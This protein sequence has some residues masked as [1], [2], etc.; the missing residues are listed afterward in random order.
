IFLLKIPSKIK[1]GENGQKAI[2]MLDDMRRPFLEIKEA[3][4]R[5]IETGNIKSAYSDFSKAV[6]SAD[7][8]LFRYKQ[9]AQ[10]NPDLFRNVVQLSKVY[11]EW[12]ITERYLFDYYHAIS[13]YDL[14]IASERLLNTMSRLG[15]GEIPIH[16]DISA[17][18]KAN[19]AL[20]TLAG[21]L[22]LYLIGL[23][24][25]Q[26]RARARTF[27]ILL[28]DR[29]SALKLVE[30]K[31]GELETALLKSESA[32]RAKSDFLSNM[33]HELRTPLNSVI[34]F[35]EVLTE[36]LA[37]SITD[38]QKEYVLNIWKSGRHLLRL[39]ND[40]MDLSKIEAGKM[41]LE[42]SDFDLKQLIEG[43]LLLFKEKSIKHSIGLRSDIPYDTCLITADERK[44]KQVILNLL[45]NA[46]KFMDD[47]GSVSVQARLVHCSQSTVHGEEKSSQFTV[48][49][50]SSSQFTV[51]SSQ[52]EKESS[53]VNSEP[54]TVN[55]E[56]ADFIEISVTDTG[57]GISSEDQKR[58][59]QPFQ[60]LEST[61][62]KKYEGTGL[63]L[64]ISKKIV[65]LHGGRI[66]V[67]SE[68]GKGSRFI[69]IIPIRK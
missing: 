16:E 1:Q 69:F 48:H 5:L 60:Q 12:V 29:S 28:H 9:L 31:S 44:I 64:S 34:G 11:E 37:G 24:L 26:Q 58:L 21:L 18:S 13:L 53:A 66:W 41:E 49:G 47:G 62:T 40:I 43:C 52:I 22:F 55:R 63:G 19:H 57:I 4:S 23:V 67:E 30:E 20:M 42:L 32:S 27:Q 59:F 15:D 10:Y 14:G 68:E 46:F 17:G 54:S 35:S 50:Q 61:L 39:I 36:G 25:L 65:E 56:L 7:S 51:H 33:S 2:Q 38:E 6:E 45:G 8:R 3:E